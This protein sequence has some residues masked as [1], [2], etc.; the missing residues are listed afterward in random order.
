MKDRKI[1]MVGLDMDGTVLNDEK[2]VTKHTKEV[3]E[4]AIAQG[5]VVLPVTGR[6][7][8]GL[9]K[10]FMEIAGLSYALTSNG[11]RVINL[12]T[13]E[14]IYE[15]LIP[16][17]VTDRFIQKVSQW[18]DCVWEVYIKG[19]IY[20]PVE[21]YHL[22]N[23]PDME[24]AMRE[25]LI[26]SRNPVENLYEKLQ[27]AQPGMEKLHMMFQDTEHRNRRMKELKKEFPELG[28]HYAN[29]Y[30]MEIISAK[31]GKGSSLLEL[32]RKLGIQKEE[33]MACG[34]ASNDWDMLKKV[35]FPVVM[36]NGDRETKN[37]A[38]FVTRSNN[39]DGV[40]YAVEQF[41]LK[42]P[43]KIQKA[44]EGQLSQILKIIFQAQEDMKIEGIPQWQNGYPDQTTL[45]K[46]VKNGYG[47]VVT[48]RE[49]V[50]AYCALCFGEDPTYRWIENG[51]WKGDDSYG[52]VHRLVVDKKVQEQGVARFLYN[53]MERICRE[54]QVG[55]V[56]I[57]THKE[58]KK[59]QKW[60]KKQKFSYCGTIHVSDGTPR[61]A[62]EKLLYLR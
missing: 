36:E 55:S 27:K 39:E 52:T 62:F 24:P 57:D 48:E 51:E 33:I 59:M 44:K 4:K 6:P 2:K 45:L 16:W 47:Y 42:T 38:A 46:D 56:R 29:T 5:V 7:E 35:G 53:G 15:E 43:W 19:K 20:R 13:G 14:E 41:A 60:L 8:C 31:A 21:E 3:L 22:P 49:K 50:L 12:V 25:Y 23:H 10:E 58:N 26:K 1:R 11:T 18:K 34:D 28:V 37:L 61:D 54:H 9:P 30:N 17:E 40:A 32:G